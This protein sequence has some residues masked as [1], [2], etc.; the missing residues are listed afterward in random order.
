M[1]DKLFMQLHMNGGAR[2]WGVPV[3]GGVH[4]NRCACEEEGGGGV[5]KWEGVY[6]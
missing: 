6:K 1:L 5:C 3:S 4:M 2:K